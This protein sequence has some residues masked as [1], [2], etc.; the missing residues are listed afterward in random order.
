MDEESRKKAFDVAVRL[1]AGRAHSRRELEAKL[2][3]KGFT[4]EATSQALNRLDQLRLIDDRAYAESFTNGLCHRRPEGARKVRARLKQKGLA[5]DIIDE[6]LA[7]SDQSFL[8]RSAAEKK[9]RTISGPPETKK[10][11][12]I[13]FLQYR[14][15]DWDTIRETVREV[16][17][18][19]AKDNMDLMD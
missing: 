3:K 18:D 1:L 9:W 17:S 6:T 7:A 16:T 10:K 13:A 8:C 15:F 4:H 14:G 11:K 12:L 2:R 19:K 5:D